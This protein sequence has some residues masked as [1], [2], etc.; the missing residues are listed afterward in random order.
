[1]LG[2]LDVLAGLTLLVSGAVAWRKRRGSRVG[3]LLVLTGGCWFAG[4][5]LGTLAFLHRGP[6]VQLHVSYPTGR[7]HGRLAT[8]V[9][10]VAW[11]AGPLEGIRPFPWLTL[12]LSALVALTA[13]DIYTRSSG[14]ARKAG[15][16]ALASALLF[17]SVLAAGSMNR[18]GD[19][20]FDT[21]IA[22]AYD[23]LVVLIAGWL[24][25]DLLA[26]RWTDA[27][28]TDLVT[29]LGGEPDTLGLQ[30][31]LRRALGDPTLVVGFYMAD[32]GSYVG[33]DGLP[34]DP[35]ASRDQVATPVDEG[36]SP[37]AILLHAPAALDEPELLTAVTAAVRLTVGNV[38]LRAKVGDQLADLTNARRA[39]VEAADQQRS[40]VAS[41][42]E[43][44]A[45]R[46]LAAVDAALAG[47]SA[48]DLRS[49][50][51]AARAE[52]RDLARGI[53]PRELDEAGLGGALTSLA[54]RSAVSTAVDIRV[55]RLQPVLESALYFV[56]AE[57]L[58]N[59]AKH[60]RADAARIDAREDAGS[61]G[62]IWATIQVTDNGVGGADP[63]GHGLRGL[64]DRVEALGGELTIAAGTMGGTQLRARVPV[65]GVSL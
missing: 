53:R 37:V 4:T 47:L 10:A 31:A 46:H 13:L 32:R 23:L 3:L 63:A 40:A 25:F 30:S 55:A 24:T 39:L 64:A 58:T 42:L 35:S 11:V 17:A 45:D 52:L 57:A 54:A 19:L 49:E 36:G 16:P 62:Q 33:D 20:G 38:A 9:V 56:A 43:L 48:P 61:D 65:P 44:G 2:A 18:L 51:A 26:G 41:Q 7:L 50:L 34:L 59:I 6:L 22:T 28:V 8:A 21:S 12:G 60:A 27:T 15:G 1:M 5:A 14:N 29:Q